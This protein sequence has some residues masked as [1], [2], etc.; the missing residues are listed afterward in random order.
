MPH[1]AP[2]GVTQM[3]HCRA[4]SR[5]TGRTPSSLRGTSG[6]CYAG[7]HKRHAACPEALHFRHTLR[8]WRR[9]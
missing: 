6:S 5:S 7:L 1:H 4:A 2:W 3:S 8:R 9:R